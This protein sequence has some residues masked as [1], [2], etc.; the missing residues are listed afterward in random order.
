MKNDDVNS[1]HNHLNSINQHVKFT[2][3]LP[4]V[5]EDGI[6]ISFLDTQTTVSPNG[7]VMVAVHRKSTDTEKYLPFD[8]HNPEQHKAAVVRTL[9][10]RANVIPTTAQGKEIEKENVRRALHTNG[11]TSAFINKA[12]NKIRPNNRTQTDLEAVEAPKG[13]T[14][15]PYVRDISE[16]INRILAGAKVR[17]TYKPKSQLK[18]I[19]YKFKCKSCDFVYIGGEQTKLEITVGRA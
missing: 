1:F 13:Y 4:T 12:T 10:H 15:I 5:S 3:E 18:G 11:Y 9:Y 7:E 14:C 2:I 17:T 19:V 6:S 16:T 8:S